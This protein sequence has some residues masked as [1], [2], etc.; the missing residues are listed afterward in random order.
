MKNGNPVLPSGY[1][2]QLQEGM[3]V[4]T[5]ISPYP[6]GLLHKAKPLLCLVSMY[7]NIER[8]PSDAL[9]FYERHLR[10]GHASYLCCFVWCT[11]AHT[12]GTMCIL[13]IE[14]VDFP[15]NALKKINRISAQIETGPCHYSNVKRNLQVSIDWH[16]RYIYRYS[17]K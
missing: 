10:D 1:S 2:Y 15:A 13:N 16:Q 17:M 9:L 12:Q 8:K 7:M 14:S 3:I 11:A 5:S 4:C 6:S